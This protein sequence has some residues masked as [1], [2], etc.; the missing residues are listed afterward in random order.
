MAV[1]HLD[2][3]IGRGE[4][5]GLLGP[6]GA[7]KTT[8]V[9]MISTLT[10]KSAGSITMNG[11]SIDRDKTALKRMIGV[12][13]Q[14][15][16]LESELTARENLDVHGRVY[17]MPTP[18]RRARIAELLDL[19]QLSDR[20]DEVVKSFSG[21]MRQKMMIVRGMMHQPA[22]LLLDEPSAGLDAGAR[23]KIWDLLRSLKAQGVTVL[24]TTHYIEEAEALCDRVGLM[25][26]G[27]LVRCGTPAELI[28]TVGAF[29]VDYFDGEHTQTAF[30][31]SRAEA[32]AFAA[33]TIGAATIRS[34]NLEDVFLD[35]TNRQVSP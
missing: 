24:L 13:P 12:V 18:V 23:R 17:G 35:L 1:D 2:L 30:F 21:G 4:F 9:R 3:S 8:T 5:F 34:A 26:Q 33:E 10:P 27:R 32:G 29:V 16:N 31:D 15:S 19:I 7:G 6:N 11:Q 22:L 25:D 28:A 14:R 20:A